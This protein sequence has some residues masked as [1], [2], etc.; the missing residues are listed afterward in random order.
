MV[1]LSLPQW[2]CMMGQWSFTSSCFEE[3]EEEK[4]QLIA[5]VH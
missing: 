1:S 2:L 4:Q 5:A 3:E